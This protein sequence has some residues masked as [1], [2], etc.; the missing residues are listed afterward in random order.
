MA[1]PAYKKS[2]DDAAT[3]VGAKTENPEK[4]LI[5]MNTTA[6]DRQN[7][8]DNP[9][10]ATKSKP[11]VPTALGQELQRERES[12]GMSREE[13]A[14]RIEILDRRRL[15]RLNDHP[16]EEGIAIA[17]RRVRMMERSRV[18][19]PPAEEIH[20]WI[21]LIWVAPVGA[22]DDEVLQG[23]D[24]HVA[25]VKGL[26]REHLAELGAATARAVRDSEDRDS[27]IRDAIEPTL[28]WSLT[29]ARTTYNP[30]YIERDEAVQ[31]YL[32][33]VMRNLV[34]AD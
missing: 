27:A 34:E 22:S 12:A 18:W 31:I 3:S 30:R 28:D 10:T 29:G 13:L 32:A 5:T 14:R 6:T 2:P 19:N 4:E 16:L 21:E 8:G 7:I 9:E 11:R 26:Q 23:W 33:A 15:P 20:M 25:V 24:Q 1:R 17:A